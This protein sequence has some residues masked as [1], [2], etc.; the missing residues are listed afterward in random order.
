MM[1]IPLLAQENFSPENYW[2][3]PSKSAIPPDEHGPLGLQQKDFLSDVTSNVHN[4][5]YGFDG[6]P[7]QAGALRVAAAYML[8]ENQARVGRGLYATDLTAQEYLKQQIILEDMQEDMQSAALAER[9]DANVEDW[10]TTQRL[11]RT[12]L[13]RP[14]AAQLKQRAGRISI[15][16]V[17]WEK[18]NGLLAPS[19]F[20]E[21]VTDILPG[22]EFDKE[23]RDVTHQYVLRLARKALKNRPEGVSVEEFS[24]RASRRGL[25][26]DIGASSAIS[27]LVQINALVRSQDGTKVTPTDLI[28]D[29]RHSAPIEHA[30][31]AKLRLIKQAKRAA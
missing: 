1:N 30:R 19:P 15:G 13:L 3:M 8:D 9:L 14:I 12:E 28:T 4:P 18:Q 22:G 17:L 10:H 5:D 11:Q 20:E 27:H 23:V 31:R 25:F 6:T 24:Q 29:N 2:Q 26:E 16:Q 7:A 21:S